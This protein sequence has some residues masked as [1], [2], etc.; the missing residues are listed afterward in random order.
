MHTSG[1]GSVLIELWVALLL[2]NSVLYIG[3]EMGVHFVFGIMSNGCVK[4]VGEILLNAV[5]FYSGH[6]TRECYYVG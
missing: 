6:C 1:R 2:L 5:G 4:C 3:I